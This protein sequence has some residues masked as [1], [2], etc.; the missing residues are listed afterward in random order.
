ML[1]A[2]DGE[3]LTG[4]RDG[5]ISLSKGLTAFRVHTEDSARVA[6]FAYAFSS[7]TVSWTPPRAL[8][9]SLLGTQGLFLKSGAFSSLKDS[10]SCQ[11]RPHTRVCTVLLAG[12]GSKAKIRFSYLLSPN[13]VINTVLS[14][15]K[16]RISMT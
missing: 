10:E 13:N 12:H 14:L 4:L 1:C 5:F 6:A 11:H 2:S 15:L 9:F 8:R 3:L 7:R 16:S